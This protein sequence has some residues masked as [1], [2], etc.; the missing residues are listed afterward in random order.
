MRRLILLLLLPFWSSAQLPIIYADVPDP[1]MIRVGDTNY[2]SST[3][4]HKNP[5]VPVMK[6][7]DLVN[8]EII[9]YAYEELEPDLDLGTGK[10]MYGKGSWASS[11]RYHEGTYYLSTFALNAGKTYIFTTKDIEKGP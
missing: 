3:T 1:S 10:S 5:G 2:M 4:M 8:W 6:S 7:K 11:L 9:H